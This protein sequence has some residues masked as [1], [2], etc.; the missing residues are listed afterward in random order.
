MRKLESLGTEQNRKTYARHGAT[1]PCYGVSFA[2]LGKMQKQI[3]RDHALASALWRTGNFDA[4]NLAMLV[5]DAEAMTSK[6]LDEWSAQA[7]HCLAWLFARKI[8]ACNPLGKKKAE[9]WT[10]A[11]NE[12]R[13]EAAYMTLAVHAMENRDEP[14]AYFEDWLGKI[15]SGI[16]K[17]PNRSRHGMNAL[18]IAIGIRNKRLQKLAL[19][20]AARIG[21]VEVDHGDT[22]C[23]TPDAAAY[24]KKTAARAAA[25]A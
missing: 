12:C 3:K 24:I 18:L 11:K 23:K 1:P 4:R 22:A 2:N 9:R 5:A 16:H 25:R 6:E 7:N 14:D 19:A 13:A 15:E 17:A 21:K 10:T 20:A 8:L